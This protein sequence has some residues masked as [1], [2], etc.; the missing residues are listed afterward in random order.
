MGIKEQAMGSKAMSGDVEKF[1]DL[2]TPSEDIQIRKH[3][4]G[5][6]V[7][8]HEHF[9]KHGAGHDIH[10]KAVEKMCMGGSAKVK[11]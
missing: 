2:K 7:P 4:A 1:N 3:M 10:F 9:Q 11:K 5:G 6:H 8:H